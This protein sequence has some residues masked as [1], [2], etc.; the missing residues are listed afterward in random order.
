LKRFLLAQDPTAP[1]FFGEQFISGYGQRYMT[2][3]GGYVLSKESLQKF[4]GLLKDNRTDEEVGC[5]RSK[6]TSEEDPSICRLVMLIILTV[7]LS[8]LNC[9]A[10]YCLNILKVKA[11]DSRDLSGM[12]RFSQHSGVKR[13]EFWNSKA[14]F[15]WNYQHYKSTQIVSKKRALGK[16]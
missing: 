6:D 2:G 1:L 7:N 4:I 10:A 9:I 16:I 11:T 13:G 5:D 12:N 14:H 8:I 15:Y 3:G